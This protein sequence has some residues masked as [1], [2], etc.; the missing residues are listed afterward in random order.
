MG[1]RFDPRLGPGGATHRQP[2]E[3]ACTTG[4]SSAAREQ[5]A[6]RRRLRSRVRPFATFRSLRCRSLSLRVRGFSC[7]RF[8]FLSDGGGSY[9]SSASGGGGGGCARGGAA[10]TAA[11]S[12]GFLS[13]RVVRSTQLPLRSYL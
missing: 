9:S 13:R 11:L 8:F 12:G 10:A 5:R 6:R 4:G 1:V 7:C 2:S 3:A